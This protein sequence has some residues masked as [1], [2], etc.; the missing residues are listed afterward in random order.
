MYSYL[1][2][3]EMYENFSIVTSF[4]LIYIFVY[5]WWGMIEKNLSKT[6]VNV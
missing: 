2:K 4:L 3:Y 5:A 6:K 1:N